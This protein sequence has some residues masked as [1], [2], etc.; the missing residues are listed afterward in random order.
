[1]EIVQKVASEILRT[2]A[3][4]LLA[5]SAV[6]EGAHQCTCHCP[7]VGHSASELSLIGIAIAVTLFIGFWLGWNFKI[8]SSVPQVSTT[9][10]PVLVQKAIQEPTTQESPVQWPSRR[11]E[12]LEQLAL[13]RSRKSDGSSSR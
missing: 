2:S 12:A 10:Q 5:S 9:S 6:R 4:G 11:Q 1:M 8:R 3:A 13:L 7:V